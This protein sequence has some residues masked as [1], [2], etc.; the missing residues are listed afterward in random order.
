MYGVHDGRL[1]LGHRSHERINI[2]KTRAQQ[3]VETTNN[4]ILKRIL[5]RQST[6]ETGTHDS[7]DSATLIIA[8]IVS[9]QVTCP[10]PVSFFIT[11]INTP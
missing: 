4:K 3:T 7:H 9:V 5:K 10:V 2:D 8:T 6:I 1:Q 11:P